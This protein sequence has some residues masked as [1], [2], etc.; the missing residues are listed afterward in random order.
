MKE[1]IGYRMTLDDTIEFYQRCIDRKATTRDAKMAIL[2][3]LQTELRAIA[4]NE[5][6]LENQLRNKK[7][8]KIKGEE[9]V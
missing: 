9:N 4:L 5:K 2:K 3:E 6:D 1:P 7:V 8:L